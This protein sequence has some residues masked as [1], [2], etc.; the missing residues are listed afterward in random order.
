MVG[1]GLSMSTAANYTT[2]G[3]LLQDRYELIQVVSSN[4]LSQ[5]YIAADHSHSDKPKCIV[6]TLWLQ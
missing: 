2:S 6:K 5:V 3:Q 1:K 4:A